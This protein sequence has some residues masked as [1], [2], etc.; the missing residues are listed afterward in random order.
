MRIWN[1]KSLIRK[2]KKKHYEKP[3]HPQLL[4]ET[5][6]VAPLTIHAASTNTVYK[7][8][9]RKRTWGMRDYTIQGHSR[10]RNETKFHPLLRPQTSII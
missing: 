1:K 9:G 5:K 2:R 8:H 7:G 6:L 10:R 4:L 3:T